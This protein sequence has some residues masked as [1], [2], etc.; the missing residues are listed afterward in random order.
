MWLLWL[1]KLFW[2]TKSKLWIH[3]RDQNMKAQK[4]VSMSGCLK[5]FLQ[6]FRNLPWS[7]HMGKHPACH[8]SNHHTRIS[9]EYTILVQFKCLIV[10]HPL[11]FD[12]CV[13]IWYSF[14]L[15]CV[16][17]T[18]LLIFFAYIYIS[19]LFISFIFLIFLYYLL[20]F[21]FLWCYIRKM[22]HRIRLG[23]LYF[24]F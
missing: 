9:Q 16:P 5:I 11:L 6:L 18:Y 13:S 15:R 24:K 23:R 4:M 14:S 1:M 8:F 22:Y 21:T 7:S 17:I 10:N 12:L 3:T 20:L 2:E 19:T